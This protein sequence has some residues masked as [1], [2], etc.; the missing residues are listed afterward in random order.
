MVFGEVVLCC[1]VVYEF[2]GVVGVIMFWNFFVFVNIEKVVLVFFV[3]CMVVFKLVFEILFFGVIFG[4]FVIVVGLL[5]GVLNVV[6][7]SDLV[8]VGEMF[9]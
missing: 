9:V 8:M 1:K 4:E 5:V 6:M 3:G 2:V 7:G